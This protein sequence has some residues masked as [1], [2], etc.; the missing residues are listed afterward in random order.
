MTSEQGGKGEKK[1]IIRTILPDGERYDFSYLF[2]SQ[3][4][5]QEIMLALRDMVIPGTRMQVIEITLGD[6]AG[7]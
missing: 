7:E 2:S 4:Q 1:W 3:E 5:A 6:S